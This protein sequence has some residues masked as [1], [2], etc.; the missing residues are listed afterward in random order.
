LFVQ[1]PPVAAKVAAVRLLNVFNSLAQ[2]TRQK[3][4]CR[5]KSDNRWG[6]YLIE[7]KRT[8]FL[9]ERDAP[10]LRFWRRF[11]CAS[12][13]RPPAFQFLNR[14]PLG[15]LGASFEAVAI[16]AGAVLSYTF[17]KFGAFGRP[18]RPHISLRTAGAFA[19]H[20]RSLLQVAVT[21]RVQVTESLSDARA[22]GL[23]S[24][25][26]INGPEQHP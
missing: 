8:I 24:I 19:V 20:V 6:V 16:T 15:V 5:Q 12:L 7:N 14:W 17:D 18:H 10:P 3:S 25:P 13:M 1:L 9:T 4:N 22:H 2:Y 11:V 21:Q 23:D 26:G